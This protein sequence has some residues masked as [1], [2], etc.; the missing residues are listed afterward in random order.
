M[1]QSR[2]QSYHPKDQEKIKS[3]LYDGN[4][5]S[6]PNH[7]EEDWLDLF[8][9]LSNKSLKETSDGST[10]F[11]YK[12]PEGAKEL[13]DIISAQDMNAQMGEIGRAWKRY[14]MCSHS[15][16]LRDIRKIIFYA[17]AEEERL[18]KYEENRKTIKPPVVTGFTNPTF[19]GSCTRCS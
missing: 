4:V 18:L 6:L 17:Q 9:S 10:A 19:L 2:Y 5:E 11:Y 8:K 1:S 12:L 15:D 3:L 7:N 16:K 13:Q 14:G